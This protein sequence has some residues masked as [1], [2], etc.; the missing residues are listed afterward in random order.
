LQAGINIRVLLTE[1]MG[2]GVDTPDD[3]EKVRRIFYEQGQ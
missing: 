1:A 2:P 3:L